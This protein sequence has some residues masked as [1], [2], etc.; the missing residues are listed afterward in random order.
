MDK[1][2]IRSYFYSL[3]TFHLLLP[4]SLAPFNEYFSLDD[5]FLLDSDWPFVRFC[6]AFAQHPALARKTSDCNYISN[7]VNS[8]PHNQ[9]VP[10]AVAMVH[11]IARNKV[12]GAK[13]PGGSSYS[14]PSNCH[15]VL[16]VTVFCAVPADSL[17]YADEIFQLFHPAVTWSLPGIVR[18]VTAFAYLWQIHRR[19]T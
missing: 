6:P 16:T 8:L 17:R 11:N 7:F 13:E 19:R 12:A 2:D 5:Y 3:W 9:L 10:E 15:N 1:G 18:I 4:T 14:Q